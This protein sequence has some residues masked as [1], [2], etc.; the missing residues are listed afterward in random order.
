MSSHFHFGSGPQ[1][2]QGSTQ[3]ETPVALQHVVETNLQPHSLTTSIL[4]CQLATLSSSCIPFIEFPAVSFDCNSTSVA[5]PNRRTLRSDLPSYFGEH[6]RSAA[7]LLM[8]DSFLFYTCSDIYRCVPYTYD[9]EASATG[10]HFHQA[11]C[12][13]ASKPYGTHIYTH[14]RFIFR[15]TNEP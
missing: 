9:N 4:H 5:A 14:S 13:F 1:T 6:K 15:N 11:Y 10:R 2:I 8:S 3:P 12:N 7:S